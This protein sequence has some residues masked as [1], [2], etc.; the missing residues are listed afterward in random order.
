MS[1]RR[2]VPMAGGYGP[3]PLTPTLSPGER[4][5]CRPSVGESSTVGK[6]AAWALLFP[7]PGGEGKGEGERY[8]L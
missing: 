5:H 1:R 8:V 6:Y 4:E 2:I 7:L 3:F